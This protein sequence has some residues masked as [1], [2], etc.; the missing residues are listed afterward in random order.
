MENATESVTQPVENSVQTETNQTETRQEHSPVDDYKRDMFKYKQQARELQEKLEAIELEKQAKKGNYQEVISKLK[1]DLKNA[2]AESQKQKLDFAQS[3]LDE[4]I[5]TTAMSK[6][7]KDKKLEA[8]MKLVDDN[9]KSVVEFDERFNIKQEDVSNLVEEHLQ[10]YA[11]VFARDVRVVDAPPN[12]KPLNK[13][14][15]KLDLNSMSG[16]E[17][18]NYILKNKDKLK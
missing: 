9:S 16:D 13:T 12:S 14:E 4:A 6:G 18:F 10:R 5:K 1:D 15:P 8:F 11:D 3:R 7:L 17:V 2:K